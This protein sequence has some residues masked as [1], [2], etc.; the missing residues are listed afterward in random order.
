MFRWC[1]SLGGIWGDGV[2]R[3]GSY[4]LLPSVVLLGDIEPVLCGVDH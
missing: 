4:P 3:L 2:D 1:K